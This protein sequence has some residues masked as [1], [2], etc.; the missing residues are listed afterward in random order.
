[1]NTIQN[2]WINITTLKSNGGYQN[3]HQSIRI[4]LKIPAHPMTGENCLIEILQSNETLKSWIKNDAI[5]QVLLVW[6]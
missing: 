4:K 6:I 5:K 1:M 3:R 2:K